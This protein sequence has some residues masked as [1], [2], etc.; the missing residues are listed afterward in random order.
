M[1]ILLILLDSRQ[2]LTTA[3]SG[4]LGS[5]TLRHCFK[6]YAAC[7]AIAFRETFREQGADISCGYYAVS[8]V[9]VSATTRLAYSYDNMYI[10]MYLDTYVR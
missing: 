8:S 3:L 10:Y 1:C 9:S 6:G 5:V 2:S 4:R 7:H